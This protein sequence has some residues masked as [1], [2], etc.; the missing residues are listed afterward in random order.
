MPWQRAGTV[1]VTSGSTTVTGTNA[2]FAANARAGDSFIGPDGRNYEVSNI[3]SAT[4]LSILPA[5]QGPTAAGAAYSIMPVPGYDKALS[6]AFNNLNIQFGGVLAVLGPTA[7]QAGVRASLSLTNTDGL[8]EGLVNKYMNAPAVRTTPLTGLNITAQGAI[9]AADTVLT[10]LG[11]LQA[12]KVAKGANSDITSL[13]G[14]TT[15]LSVAQG[16]TGNT[17]G[18]AEKL[19]AAAILGTVSHN[20]GVP[21]GSI[22]ERGFNANGMYVRYADGTQICTRIVSIAAIAPTPNGSVYVGSYIAGPQFA[23]PFIEPPVSTC[24]YVGSTQLAWFSCAFPA[25]TT[26]FHSAYP[27]HPTGVQFSASVQ[28]LAVGRWF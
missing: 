11:K 20:V 14:L 4:V 27:I 26:N 22:M 5:Y 7:T 3:A 24:S 6:D 8:P 15:A 1:A 18:T 19:A 2:N 23:S 25:S 12:T 17:T 21:T 16:G 28:Y 10:A 13:S 9:A